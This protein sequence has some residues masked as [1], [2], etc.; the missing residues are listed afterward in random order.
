MFPRFRTHK[1]NAKKTKCL[2]GHDH[3]S[4]K[5]AKYCD[6]LEDQ[7][8]KKLIQTYIIETPFVIMDKFR[9]PHGPMIRE[10]KYIADFVVKTWS[11]EIHVIDAKGFRTPEFKVKWKLLQEKYKGCPEY[12]FILV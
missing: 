4:K 8:S 2:Q 1:F 3:R 11:G 9:S 6:S 5:E 7:Y 12:K 10:I